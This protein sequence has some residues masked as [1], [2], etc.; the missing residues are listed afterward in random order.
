MLSCMFSKQLFYLILFR[1]FSIIFPPNIS[2]SALFSST[3]TRKGGG[4]G[5][6]G[7]NSTMSLPLV[8]SLADPASLSTVSNSRKEENNNCFI[9]ISLYALFL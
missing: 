9:V 6:K 3:D 4:N 7:A 1:N 5:S 2:G 8:P